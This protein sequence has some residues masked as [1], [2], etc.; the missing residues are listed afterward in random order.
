MKL[1]FDI[2]TGQVN[3]AASANG[4]RCK[5]ST[6]DCYGAIDGVNNPTGRWEIELTSI[7]DQSI[8]ITFASA[9]TIQRVV[10]RRT[11]FANER[12]CKKMFLQFGGSK[13]VSNEYMIYANC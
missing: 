6:G 11:F 4:A 13:T 12:N 8:E 10:L 1:N 7:V 2:L 5:A 3:H 9:V